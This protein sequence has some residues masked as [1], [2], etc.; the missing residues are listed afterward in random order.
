MGTPYGYTPMFDVY[1]IQEAMNATYSAIATNQNAFAVQNIFIPTG[2][3]LAMNSLEGAL[4]I[5]EGDAKPEPLNLVTH[6]TRSV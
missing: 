1:P 2:A 3:N 5:I 4:N 6:A